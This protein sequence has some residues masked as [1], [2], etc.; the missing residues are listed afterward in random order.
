MRGFV[1]SG[2]VLEMQQHEM[3]VFQKLTG[4]QGGQ[5]LGIKGGQITLWAAGN[6]NL[7]RCNLIPMKSGISLEKPVS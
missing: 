3:W 2:G 5:L 7:H 6:N 4:F 1:Y